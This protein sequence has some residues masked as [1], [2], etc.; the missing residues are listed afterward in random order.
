[1]KNLIL[2]ISICSLAGCSSLKKSLAYGGLV[3]GVLGGFAGAELSPNKESKM[4]NALVFGTTGIVAGAALAY[5]FR[6]DDPDNREMDQMILEDKKELS[7]F[8]EAK[9]EK[10]K[11]IPA[12]TTNEIKVVGDL[13]PEELREVVKKQVIREHILPQRVEKGAD[14]KTFVYPE[15]KVI[16]YDYE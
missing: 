9:N 14:G 6:A 3:G 13:V 10:I 1:M 8:N 5:Y 15:S 11:V 16:E 7:H 4:A 12:K 2:L